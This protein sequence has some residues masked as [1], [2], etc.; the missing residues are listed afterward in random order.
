MYCRYSTATKCS[1]LFSNAQR[2]NLV[3]DEQAPI[4]QIISK[5]YFFQ[6]RTLEQTRLG[7]FILSTNDLI[8]NFMLQNTRSLLEGTLSGTSY[9]SKT[10]CILKSITK[11]LNKRYLESCCQPYALIFPLIG[12]LRSYWS[13]H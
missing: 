5:N 6:N 11:I 1:K 10:K 8:N 7:N 4:A 13:V 9:I 12:H 2:K 3:E